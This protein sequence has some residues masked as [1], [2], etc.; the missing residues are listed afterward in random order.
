MIVEVSIPEV[1]AI[2]VDVAVSTTGGLIVI[3]YA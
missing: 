2:D 1:I 3:V